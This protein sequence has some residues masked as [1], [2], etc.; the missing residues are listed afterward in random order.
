MYLDIFNFS[1]NQFFKVIKWLKNGK[2][3]EDNEKKNK[4]HELSSE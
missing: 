3:M 1:L 4:W 2:G